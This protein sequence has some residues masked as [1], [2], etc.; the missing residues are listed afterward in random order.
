MTARPLVVISHGN[1]HNYQQ[2]DYL[3]RHLAEH[4]FVVMAHTNL[5]GPGIETASAS[6]L[7]NTDTFLGN[8]AEIDGGVLVGKIDAQKIAWIGHSRGGE[9]VVRAY[10]RLVTKNFLPLHFQVES[11]RF[12][13]SIAPTTFLPASQVHSEDVTYHMFVG[14]ADGDVSGQPM[15]VVM[16]MPIYERA[17]GEKILIYVQGAGHNVFNDDARDEGDGPDRLK[18]E[19]VHL[20]SK[21]TY[22]ALLQTYLEGDSRWRPYFVNSWSYLRFQEIPSSFKIS[23]EFKWAEKDANFLDID[24]FQSNEG[25]DVASSRSTVSATVQNISEGILQDHDRDFAYR[26][27]DMMNGMTRYIDGPA[28]KGMIFDWD[29]KIFDL[30]YKLAADITDFSAYEGLTFRAAQGSRHPFTTRLN[31]DLEFAVQIEDGQGEVSILSSKNFGKI[32]SPY[33]RSGGWACEFNTLHIP[34]K[35]FLAINSNL[36]LKRISKLVFLF[37]SEV[38]SAAGRMAID[39]IGLIHGEE[40]L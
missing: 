39:D 33:A 37:G 24:D 32:L 1:G 31:A 38:G 30:T 22:L 4:G 12:V 18:R 3:Q 9:G 17:R 13:S 23:N 6:T 40:S 14:G 19:E 21:T 27:A 28:P 16:S 8:L 5:T 29:G 26:A 20:I 7:S 35:A 15:S 34:L 2:Y 11:I 10:N 36:D 25:T